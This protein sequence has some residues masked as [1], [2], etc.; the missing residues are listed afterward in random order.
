MSKKDYKPWEEYSHIWKTESAYLS[1][2][3]GGI[4]R[5]LWS[6]NPIKLEFE[7]ERVIPIKNDNT[8]SMKRYPTVNGAMCEHCGNLF[9]AKEMEVD[10]RTGEHSLRSLED[11][12]SFV[13]G[14]VLVRKEDLAYLCKPCH[15]IKTHAERYGMTLDDAK[16]DKQA[17]EMEK[18]GVKKVVDFIEKSGI[19]PAKTKPQRREQLFEI[20]RSKK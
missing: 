11:I 3:R 2:V 20:Y 7:K 10:H 13:E 18:K 9:K 16:A 12:P 5:Y 6:K 17:I 14:I 19:M 15:G 1:F 4:R 8:R